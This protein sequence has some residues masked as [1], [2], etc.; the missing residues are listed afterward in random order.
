MT[1]LT[2]KGVH[3][4]ATVEQMWRCLAVG[5]AVKGVLCADGHLGYAQ[6]V[7]GVVAY[8]DHVSVS[9]VGYAPDGALRD[10]DAPLPTPPPAE[11]QA[12]LEAAALCNDAHLHHDGGQE[13]HLHRIDA[14]IANADAVVCQSSCVSHAAYWRMKEACKKLGKP[15]VF[16]PSPGVGSF[17]RSLAALTHAAPDQQI[18]RLAN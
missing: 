18:I 11:V 17:A 6:P 4:E 3:D 5:S 13:E 14:A 2:V 1:V 9:G 12:L 7:G 15:C 10:G 16:V 8:T